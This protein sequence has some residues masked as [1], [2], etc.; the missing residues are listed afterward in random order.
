MTESPFQDIVRHRESLDNNSEN[1]ANSFL[2]VAFGI[3]EKYARHMGVLITS[4]VAANPDL[5]FMFHIFTNALWPE[6]RERL[7]ALVS[8]STSIRV[9]YMAPDLLAKL[10]VTAQYPASIYYRLLMPEVLRECAD[11][12]LYLDSDIICLNHLPLFG[13]TAL[14]G[15]PV[16]AV[17]D[18]LQVARERSNALGLRHDAYFNSGVMLI[19]VAK[20]NAGNL[21]NKVLKI[22]DER[23]ATFTLMD[24]DALNIALDGEA[25]LLA[26]AWN[27]IYNLGQM[28]QSPE[29]GT[30]FLHYTGSIKPW[31]LSGRHPL[32]RYY[33]DCEARS[34]WAG[35][36]L[37]PPATYKE[38]EVYARLSLRE[39]DFGTGLRW[40]WRYLKTKFL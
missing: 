19:D 9:Y 34:P 3:D 6:D 15:K 39:H 31:R 12:V 4:L 25:A 35:S 20:W 2:H 21:T 24:Q 17:R 30:L 23:G 8:P 32:S 10:P 40:Y 29:P 28:T 16:A 36:P 13:K 38:M 14:A 33:R 1:D 7:S 18:V 37:L 26:P 22:L 5:S 11:Y 27:M